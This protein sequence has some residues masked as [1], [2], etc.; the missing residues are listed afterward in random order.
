M[1]ILG[2]K[3]LIE[4]RRWKDGISIKGHAG[5][6]EH[7]KDIVCAA[8]SALLQ[9]FIASVEELTYDNIQSEITAGNAVIKYK[10][11]SEQGTLLVESFFCGVRMIAASYPEYVRAVDDIKSNGKKSSIETINTWKTAKV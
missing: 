6:A 3:A 5:Y 4:I 8:I 11:L 1:L 9:T 2:V 7:G 10:D